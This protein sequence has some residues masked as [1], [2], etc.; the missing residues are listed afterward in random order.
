MNKYKIVNI[1][2]NTDKKTIEKIVNQK[3]EKIIKKT[4]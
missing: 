4:G 3:I 1:Y 2:I